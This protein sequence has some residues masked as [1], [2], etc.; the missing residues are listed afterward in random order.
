MDKKPFKR[1][2]F[3]KRAATTG[4]PDIPEGAK[5]EAKILF[6]HQIVDLVEE[7]TIPLSLIMNFDQTPLK[8]AP[9]T[10]QT[11]QKKVLNML[12]FLV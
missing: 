6:F 2:G 3:V 7:I 5:K 11:L 4:R 12:A 8:Y 1:I 10:S 9:V